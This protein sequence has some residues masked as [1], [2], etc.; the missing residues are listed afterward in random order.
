MSLAQ[1]HSQLEFPDELVD[2][3]LSHLESIG[4]VERSGP[5]IRAAGFKAGLSKRQEEVRKKMLTEFGKQR[6]NPINRK[7]LLALASEAE[8]VYGYLKQMNIIVD[9][10]G[11]VFLEDDFRAMTDEIKSH[12]SRND[13]ITV[14]EARD[15]TG[16]SRK[17]VV[18]LLEELDRRRIT[19]REGDYRRL[20]E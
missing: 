5:G 2:F 8:A 9:V 4:E 7:E 12:L 14:S 13:T 1:L 18:P 3:A 10:D 19:K 20:A 17:V 6:R 11:A 16:T 15:L